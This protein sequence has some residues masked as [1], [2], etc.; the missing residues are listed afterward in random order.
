[1][2]FR[3]PYLIVEPYVF[4]SIGMMLLNAIIIPQL[5]LENICQRNFNGIICSNINTWLLKKQQDLVQK[6]S[7]F[8]LTSIL[9]TEMG[10]SILAILFI[11]PL[12][13]TIGI[14]NTMFLT[15]AFMGMNYIILII[16]TS[17]RRLF[18]PALLLVPVPFVSAC[19]SISG[20]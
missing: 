19:G 10:L 17:M 9:S 5:L 15:S 11:G 14:R 13:D 7:A 4:L 3:I 12:A 2:A 1:M 20:T 6:Q 8:W 16:L 18:H